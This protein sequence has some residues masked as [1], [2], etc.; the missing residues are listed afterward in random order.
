M[1][2]RAFTLIELLVVIA[3]IAILA[4]ILFPVFAQAKMSAKK[5]AD[6]SNL[7]QQGLAIAMYTADYDDASVP[8]GLPGDA[9]RCPNGGITYWP[10]LLMPYSKNAQLFLNPAYVFEYNLNDAGGTPWVCRGSNINILD[11]YRMR[12]SY[13]MNAIEPTWWDGTPWRDAP[14]NHWGFKIRW[15]NGVLVGSNENEV[16]LPAETIRVVDGHTYGDGWRAC[17][18]DFPLFR[19]QPECT[20][21]GTG[22]EWTGG[23]SEIHGIFA[24]KI[25]IL[26]ADSHASSREWGRTY[27]SEW[28][29]QD[30]AQFD[31]YR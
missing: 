13:L 31:P 16:A 18:A 30:D 19:R 27:P 3:I 28:S 14:E 20:W 2:Q 7:K 29:L 15:E 10:S 9:Q 8:F 26:W 21:T 25:N 5:A 17:M 4:A 22:K 6:I 23:T 24:R 12:V 11:G 1:R